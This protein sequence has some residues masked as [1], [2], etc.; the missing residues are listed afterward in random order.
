MLYVCPLPFFSWKVHAKNKVM[1]AE[2]DRNVI[3]KKVMERKKLSLPPPP[4]KKKKKIGYLKK[5][6]SKMEKIKVVMMS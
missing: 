3:L 6:L 5:F 1:K 4:K 2:V